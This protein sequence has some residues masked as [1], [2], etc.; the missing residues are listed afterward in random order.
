MVIHHGDND[1]AEHFAGL[2]DDIDMT[3]MQWVE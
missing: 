1:L 3:E 2:R